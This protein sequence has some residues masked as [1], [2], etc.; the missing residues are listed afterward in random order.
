MSA[1]T[2]NEALRTM[3]WTGEEMTGHGFRIVASTLLNESGEWR[4]DAIERQLSHQEDED[5]RGAYDGAEYL[6]ER[7]RMMQTF[8]D[9]LDILRAKAICTHSTMLT[10]PPGHSLPPGYLNQP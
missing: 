1:V 4:P 3:G 8:A 2:I 10:A 7:R 9:Q 5:V 6:A